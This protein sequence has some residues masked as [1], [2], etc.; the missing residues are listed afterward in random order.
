MEQFRL[1]EKRFLRIVV[2]SMKNDF[3]QRV[4]SGEELPQMTSLLQNMQN[5]KIHF[6]VPL[7]AIKQNP[8]LYQN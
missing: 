3:T 6:P 2:S 7:K 1:L 4:T 5:L 8:K